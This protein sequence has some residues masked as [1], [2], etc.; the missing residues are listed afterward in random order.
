[1]DKN[2]QLNEDDSEVRGFKVRGFKSY[3]VELIRGNEYVHVSEFGFEIDT[4]VLLPRE[5]DVY[6]VPISVNHISNNHFTT[7][8][9]CN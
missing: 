8:I 7:I 3:S 4:S 6:V 5:V 1:M 2:D 9:S